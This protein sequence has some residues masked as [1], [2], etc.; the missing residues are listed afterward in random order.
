MPKTIGRLKTR[1]LLNTIATFLIATLLSLTSVAFADENQ[2]L[3]HLEDLKDPGSLAVKLQDTRAAVSK[4]I[5]AQLS[6]ETQ[7][8]LDEYDGISNP[9]PA[10]QK[11]LLDDLNRLLQVAPLYE[12]QHLANIELSEQT[13]ELLAQNPQSGEDLIRLNRL[14]LADVYPYELAL[15]SEKQNPDDSTGI[16]RCRENLRQIKLALENYRAETDGEPQWLS[17][18]SPQYLEE[19][20]LLCPADT[21]VGIPGVLT[22][23][24]SDPTLPCSYLYEFR[25]EQKAGQEILLEIEG[26][27]IPIVRCQHHLL[28][29]SISGK[30]YRNGPQRNI[31]NETKV[32]TRI[33][34]QPNLPADLPEEVRKQMAEQLL[35]GGNNNVKRN[36][37]Q[38]QIK[39]SDDVQTKLK[40]QLGEA[41]LESPEG[42]AI[43]QQLT[44]T[45][46]VSID[47][48]ELA[49]L[50][51][52]PMP[53]IALT[54]L[55]EK[56]VKL[57]TLRGKFVLV[58]LFSTDVPTCGPKLKQMERL[59]ANYDATQLQAVG[60]STDDSA[61][62]I[63]AFKAKHQLS[64]PIWVDKNNQIRTFLN[65]QSLLNREASEPQTELITLLLNRELVIK[66]VL[67]DVDPETLSTKIKNLIK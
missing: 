37:F 39:P 7:R 34:I 10:L 32:V 23:D 50:L 59:L 27:M 29:L 49:L 48:E 62:A 36:I 25:P 63:E 6:A 40:E 51:G 21:T 67:I 20:V 45:P 65:I 15:P 16:E 33:S 1:V 58:N 61:T 64:M 31:Y 26:D 5:A 52:K 22:D 14:L 2:F 53:D 9:S 60:I 41:F 24:G 12:A 28:N 43:L 30:L 35:K 66:D 3:F 56:P 44:P 57:E 8:L 38:I 18:L 42:K 13:Q 55:S 17:E 19:K 4:P 46:T 11:A 54:N 47:Q